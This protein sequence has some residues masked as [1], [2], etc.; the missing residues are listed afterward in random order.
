MSALRLLVVILALAFATA[1]RADE[2]LPTGA[3][4]MLKGTKRVT[5]LVFSPDGKTL[6]ASDYEHV[7]LWDTTTW[8]KG[9]LLHTR[10]AGAVPCVA[11]T[12]DSRTL[13][14]RS[15]RAVDKRDVHPAQAPVTVRFWRV[16][17]GTEITW[18]AG[19]GLHPIAFSGDGRYLALDFDIGPE[20]EFDGRPIS[21][22]SPSLFGS[23][24]GLLSF[25]VQYPLHSEFGRF[26]LLARGKPLNRYPDGAAAERPFLLNGTRTEVAHLTGLSDDGSLALEN[27][28]GFVHRPF[29]GMG[30]H[31][32]DGGRRIADT[33]SGEEV[34]RLPELQSVNPVFAPDAKTL[35]GFQ[36]SR[37]PGDQATLCVYE[38]ASGQ[39]RLRVEA[40]AVGTLA[41]SPAGKFVALSAPDNKSVRICD[42]LSGADLGRLTWPQERLHWLSALAFSADGGRL[43]TAHDDGTILIWDMDK[44]MGPSVRKPRSL[45]ADEADALWHELAAEAPRAAKAMARLMDAPPTEAVDLLRTRLRLTETQRQLDLAL[46]DLGSDTFAARQRATAQLERMGNLARPALQLAI[47][48]RPSL[49]KQRRV[50]QI[51]DRLGRPFSSP[52]GLR[53]LRLIE[54]LE[55]I[56]TKPA[57]DMLDELAKTGTDTGLP[58][59][60]RLALDRLQRH[61]KAD[62]R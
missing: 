30:G 28:A 22:T 42:L 12:P 41:V 35:I 17:E 9:H 47:A 62:R 54:L 18:L 15:Y 44:I 34:R 58:R 13:L 53:L 25:V 51:L 21:R 7:R 8:E 49:E 14:V 45:A 1:L 48:E 6:A 33:A 46:D 40:S 19:T 57:R 2:P 43:A 59:Q 24:A 55:R 23:Y 29:T 60:A 16:A 36:G 20:I 3:V 32:Y 11:F 4:T 5:G 38:I 39:E 26:R 50:E 56:D 37:H 31:S 10:L 27:I 61:A 52:A